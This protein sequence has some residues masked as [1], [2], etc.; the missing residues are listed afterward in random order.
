M[1]AP[2]V[3]LRDVV[4]KFPRW[5]WVKLFKAAELSRTVKTDDM[6]RVEKYKGNWHC[7]VSRGGFTVRER[8][9]GH[10][11]HMNPERA[12]FHLSAIS[13]RLCKKLDRM[14]PRGG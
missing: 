7:V 5:L 10:V 1:N 13:E 12:R 4:R 2:Q 3:R 11:V 6:P 14:L 8:L 9:P